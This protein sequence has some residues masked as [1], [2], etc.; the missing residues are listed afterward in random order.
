MA[1]KRKEIGS[2]LKSKDASQPD[3]IKISEDI[4]LKK[5]DTL[6]LESKKSRLAGLE[7]NIENGKLSGELADK[8]RE[9]IEKIPD[10]VRFQIVRITKD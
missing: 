1:Y 6:S 2:V 8:I 4:V 5:G 10:F 7:K 3:Y 9:S